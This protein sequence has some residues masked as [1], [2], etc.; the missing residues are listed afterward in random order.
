MPNSPQLDWPSGRTNDEALVSLPSNIAQTRPN[1]PL[2]EAAFSHAPRLLLLGLAVISLAGVAFALWLRGVPAGIPDPRLWFNAFFVLFARNEPLGLGLVALF[3]IASAL[4]FFRKRSL[5]AVASFDRILNSRWFLP[6]LLVGVFLICAVGTQIVCH[7]YALTAD[8]NL[9]DFQA[10][11]FLHGTLQARVPD[12]WLP[13]LRNLKPTFVAYHPATQSW[14]SQYLPVFAAMRAIFQSVGLQALL[15][16]LIAAVSV[17]AL[18][19]T[20]RNIWPEKDENALIAAALLG[21]S[22]QVLIM[23]MTSYAMPAHLALNTVWLWL[24]SRPNE[25]KFY[26][27]PIVGIFAIGLHQPI[28]HALFAT[29]FLVRLPLQRKW[30]PTIV[31]ALIYLVGCAIWFSWSRMFQGEGGGGVASIFRLLNP[32]MAIIQPMNLLL[33]IGWASLATPLLA[34]LGARRFFRLPPILQDAALSFLLTFGFYYFFY[35]DQAHGWGYRYVHGSLCCLILVAVAGWDQ[36]VKCVGERTA[37]SFL[38]VGLAASLLIQLPLRSMEAES[39]IRPYAR[40]AAVM[41]AVPADMVLFDPF[42]GWYSADLLRN[43][44]YLEERPL[45]AVR[46]GLNPEAVAVLR[47]AGKLQ[48]IDRPAMTR[49]GLHTARFNDFENDPFALGRGL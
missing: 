35:L 24:Y 8:E 13:L 33:I 15:N 32:R 31:F 5:G 4:I 45:V 10:K 12:Q 2:A 7:N 3:S 17:L 6:V 25:R 28:V 18:Y 29:P 36:L 19:G 23:A 38:G 37:K 46:L 1:T 22:S 44:P 48:V 27:A 43:D 49:L 14:N 16:P 20:A 47:T 40:T 30:R 39:F 34:T 9:A 42:D 21:S 26:L 11:I 41:H